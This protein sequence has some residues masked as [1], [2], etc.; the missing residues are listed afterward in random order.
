[1]LGTSR[2]CLPNEL[3][4]LILDEVHR[5]RDY[6]GLAS[7]T[8]SSSALYVLATPWLYRTVC[9]RHPTSSDV[10]HTTLISKPALAPHVRSLILGASAG[11]QLAHLEPNFLA[12]CPNLAIIQVLHFRSTSAEEG[13]IT[14]IS[15][16][17]ARRL[18]LEY[19]VPSPLAIVA[20]LAEHVDY[21]KSLEHLHIMCSLPFVLPATVLDMSAFH[22]LRD[23]SLTI[24]ISTANIGF[25]R[26]VSLFMTAPRLERLR[27]FLYPHAKAD[28][29]LSNGSGYMPD[30]RIQVVTIDIESETQYEAGTL[31]ARH[32]K[33]EIDM[34]DYG[35]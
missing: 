4:L 7:M 13:V 19:T 17:S 32:E 9:L 29:A 27:V 23:I 24:Q 33:G 31:V 22:S 2:L 6:Q 12:R 10:F 16:S 26:V 20:A 18:A 30:P 28:Q 1:M 14:L 35:V 34:W 11:A 5:L 8:R 15:A 21:A 3:I 25:G